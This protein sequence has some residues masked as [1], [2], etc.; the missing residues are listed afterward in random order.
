MTSEAT[1]IETDC[2]IEHEGRTFES[3]GAYVD[4]TYLT[5][6]IGSDGRTVTDWK[7]NALGRAVVRSSWPIHSYMADRMYAYRVTLDDGRNYSARGM[8]AGMLVRGK[9]LAA[10]RI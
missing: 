5:A 1:Y 4:D 8:G 7:G 3:G 6:Y 2:T 9:R 10:E